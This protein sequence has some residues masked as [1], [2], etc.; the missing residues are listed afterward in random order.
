[1]RVFKCNVEL[2]FQVIGRLLSELRGNGRRLRPRWGQA[3]RLG[4]A[5][6]VLDSVA[7]GGSI[8]RAGTDASGEAL[9]ASLMQG[10]KEVKEMYPV[11]HASRKLSDL[12][13]KYSATESEFL[14]VTTDGIRIVCSH[15][16]KFQMPRH[17]R[18]EWRWKGAD[19]ETA[20]LWR[21]ISSGSL[22]SIR[23]RNLYVC[24]TSTWR[25]GSS[26][27]GWLQ[28]PCSWFTASASSH[29]PDSSS[30]RSRLRQSCLGGAVLHHGS[31]R[32]RSR[33]QVVTFAYGRSLQQK[34]HQ[35]VA[36]FIGGNRISVGRRRTTKLYTFILRE[37]HISL[38][39]PAHFCVAAKLATE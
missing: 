35:C 36:G 33:E 12:E 32:L 20:A 22:S 11:P 24:A 29:F 37:N 9:G 39:E 6:W 28:P 13:K 1:M 14:G 19:R 16:S 21:P 31:T 4:G 2:K 8:R 38:V 30:P 18:A 15:I 5:P 10:E 34:S 25:V 23:K 26:D 3:V 27:S 17:L 7:A